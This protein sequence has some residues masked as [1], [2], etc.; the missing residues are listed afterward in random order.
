MAGGFRA[1]VGARHAVPLCGDE[2]LVGRGVVF[3]GA[4][5]SMNDGYPAGDDNLYRACNEEGWL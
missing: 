1:F 3:F 4:E 5:R 2:N